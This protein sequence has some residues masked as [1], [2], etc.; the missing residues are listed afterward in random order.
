MRKPFT[1]IELNCLISLVSRF[2]TFEHLR[3]PVFCLDSYFKGAIGEH[4][5]LRE[6]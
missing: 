4:G 5:G 3:T 6:V 2:L 1:G